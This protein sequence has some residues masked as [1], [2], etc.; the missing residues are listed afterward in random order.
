MVN[1]PT[2]NDSREKSSAGI[3]LESAPTGFVGRIK[4]S[5]PEGTFA[6]GAGLIVAA[7]TAYLFVIVTLN[8]LSAKEKSGF[9]AFWAL[10][11]VSGVGFFLPIEQ[12]VSRA[13]AARRAQGLG[14][15]P[16]VKRAAGLAFGL[17]VL[18]LVT[19]TSAELLGN[20][21]ISN[22]FFHGNQGLVWALALSL[23]GFF[24]M[25]L[26]RGVLSGNGR[27]RPYGE[28]MGAEGIFRLAGAIVL[29]L[30]GVKVGGLFGLCLAISPFLAVA[31]AMR[32]QRGLLPDGPPAPYS[33]LSTALGW[34]LMGS[35][36]MQI[37]GYTPLLGISLLVDTGD[38]KKD[39]AIRASF[40]SA[41]FIA[42]IPVL[43]FQAVQGTLLPKLAG[44]A[45]AG[46]SQDFRDGL[47]RLL[48]VVTGIA[49]LGT[50][51]AFTV[52]PI[53]GRLLFKDFDMSALNLGLLA[54]GS[55]VFI[56]ALTIAQA[57]IALNAHPRVAF[58][59]V[60]GVIGFVVVCAL[61]TDVFLRV[62]LGF[63]AGA[64]VSC[65]LMLLQLQR[66]MHAGLPVSAQSLVD[67]IEHEPLEL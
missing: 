5:L 62:E 66:V 29:A 15:G 52:G 13:I 34:L 4:A 67:A 46:K 7:I 41:F 43:L 27:F 65:A 38:P 25:H 31:V 35:V 56:I 39:I 63:L 42:R 12:E 61:I 14:A 64:V 1:Q 45:G 18:L 50:L 54:A 48:G 6:V 37:L 33:E 49:A 20:R 23:V 9:S 53:A 19:I 30:I 21:V 11:F 36:F 60:A 40:A 57:L 22:E 47:M 58:S 28:M 44:L 2:E 59:W 16:L 17:L 51:A 24:C 26:T 55:G 8:A 3:G 32:A 10:V